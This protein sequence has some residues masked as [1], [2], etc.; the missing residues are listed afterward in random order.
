[1][2]TVQFLNDRY[3]VNETDSSVRVAVVL[4]GTVAQ[5]ITVRY[6]LLNVLSF[7]TKSRIV[8]FHEHR[9]FE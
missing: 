4:T 6:N 5:S 9:S 8:I 3:Y 1:M 2:A 7:L